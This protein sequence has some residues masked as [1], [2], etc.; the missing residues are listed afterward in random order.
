MSML[1]EE[2]GVFGIWDPDGG[3]AN[4]T[5]NA[6]V[7]LQHRGQEGCGIAVNLDREI[8]Y[9][10]DTGLVNEVFN[11]EILEKYPGTM[12]VGHVRYSTAG[13]SFRENVQPLVLRYI[14]GTLAIA[15][16]GN[17]TNV[18]ELKSSWSITEPSFR[19]RQTPK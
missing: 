12:A 9:Y 16:N 2:C 4:V 7:A 6:L 15:H 3:C 18:E 5:C 8:S 11:N 13:G 14:K 19:Q 17:I 10:K 1:K